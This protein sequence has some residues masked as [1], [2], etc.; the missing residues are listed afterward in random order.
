M[1]IALATISDTVRALTA[2]FAG[3][4]VGGSGMAHRAISRAGARDNRRLRMA[5]Q[6]SV[7]QRVAEA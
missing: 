7:A 3:G 5:D 4:T 2:R 1:N 6:E